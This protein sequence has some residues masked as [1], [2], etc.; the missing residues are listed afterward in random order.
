MIIWLG[1]TA[2]Y[3]LSVTTVVMGCIPFF[4]QA[5]IV[6][7]D[8]VERKKSFWTSGIREMY[9]QRLSNFRLLSSETSAARSQYW[10]RSSGCGSDQNQISSKAF[11]GTLFGMTQPQ[12]KEIEGT[13]EISPEV[14][15]ILILISSWKPQR[16][17]ARF[18]LTARPGASNYFAELHKPKLS[19]QSKKLKWKWHVC[20]GWKLRRDQW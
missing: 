10:W 11:L 17:K 20:F 12:T 8:R 14:V 6:L 1:R 13:F 3:C 16:W 2:L 18:V 15:L 4:K 7:K 19:L 9:F 5:E